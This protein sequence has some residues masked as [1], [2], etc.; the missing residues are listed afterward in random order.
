MC[1]LP[2]WAAVGLHQRLSRT[3]GACGCSD[4]LVGFGEP[5]ASLFND[6]ILVE[7]REWWRMADDLTADK[8][9]VANRLR[10]QLWRLIADARA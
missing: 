2:R 5:L 10:E 9:R 4:R 1:G 8:N 6:A 3:I 7:L